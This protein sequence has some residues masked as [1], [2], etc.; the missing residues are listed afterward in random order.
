MKLQEIIKKDL[1]HAMKSEEKERMSNLISLIKMLPT[2]DIK[3]RRIKSINR[4]RMTIPIPCE[5]GKIPFRDQLLAKSP[6]FEG[7]ITFS[8]KV[9][10]VIF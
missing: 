2:N 8:G 5:T 4:S 7:S 9:A 6:L 1:S 10:N 3:Q